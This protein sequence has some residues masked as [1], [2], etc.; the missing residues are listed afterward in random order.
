MDYYHDKIPD[1]KPDT[2]IWTKEHSDHCIERLR[3]DIMCHPNT[4][5]YIPEWDK[6]HVL[7]D[8]FRMISEGQTTCVNWKALDQW[9]RRRAL[10]KGE[11]TLK[12]NPFEDRHGVRI[13][14]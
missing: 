3:D 2:G 1:Y 7:P 8:G 10:K 9:A 4:A 11:Y 12:P 13:H 5:V 6:T 14:H